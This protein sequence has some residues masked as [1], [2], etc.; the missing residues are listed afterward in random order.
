MKFKNKLNYSI[1]FRNAHLGNNIR[2]QVGGNYAKVRTVVVF[3]EMVGDYD[4]ERK[5]R[6]MGI[7]RRLAMSCF[8]MCV[9]VTR[10]CTI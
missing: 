5:E 6:K 2:R 3:Y 4:Q 8:L 10:V 7:S 9:V 1:L